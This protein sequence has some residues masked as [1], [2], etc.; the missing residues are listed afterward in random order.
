MGGEDRRDEGVVE[1]MTRE[2]DEARKDAL[3][4]NRALRSVVL[5]ETLLRESGGKLTI[6]QTQAIGRD[7]AALFMAMLQS[8]EAANCLEWIVDHPT[9]GKFTLTL[10]RCAG[11]SPMELRNVERDRANHLEQVVRH[12]CGHGGM[13]ETEWVSAL[14]TLV[15]KWKESDAKANGG[16]PWGTNR[17]TAHDTIGQVAETSLRHEV[18]GMG[19][20][21]SPVCA[22]AGG[23]TS[24]GSSGDSVADGGSV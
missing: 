13:T 8:A 10:Q 9:E 15:K 19:G 12:S 1:R 6:D 11:K 14:D 7:F 17:K 21:C 24:A 18:S 22:S 5:E 23:Q 4:A 16:D 3:I 20:P 2:R